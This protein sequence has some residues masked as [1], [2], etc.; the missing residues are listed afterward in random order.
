MTFGP[1]FLSDWFNVYKFFNLFIWTYKWVIKPKLPKNTPAL[2]LSLSSHSIWPIHLAFIKL[3]CY[4]L[5]VLSIK[6]N[7]LMYTYHRYDT[8]CVKCVFLLNQ[9]S[10]LLIAFTSVSQVEGN[11]FYHCG[12][13]QHLLYGFYR[14]S[15][16]NIPQNASGDDKQKLVIELKGGLVARLSQN[17]FF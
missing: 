15:K 12:R 10:W 17:N 13:H 11:G 9:S 5:K 4:Y 14:F 7:L 2:L 3:F 6:H 8:R 16:K 1:V